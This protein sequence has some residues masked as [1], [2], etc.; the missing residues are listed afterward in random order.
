M[1]NKHGMGQLGKTNGN[2]MRKLIV[3]ITLIVLSINANALNVGDT[4][5]ASNWDAGGAVLSIRGKISGAY[6]ISNA[7][8]DANLFIQIFDTTITLGAN[9]RC[10]KFSAMWYG[11]NPS[12]DDNSVCLQK[13]INACQDRQ[14][15]LFIPGGNY[16]TTQPLMVIKGEY[17]NYEQTSIKITGTASFWDNGGGSQIT[18][19]GD[20]CAI[21]LQL[22]KGTEISHLIISGVWVSP[23]GT[24][25]AYF[26]T[27]YDNYENQAEHGNGQGIWVDPIGNWSQRSGSTGCYFHDLKIEKFKTLIQIS[28]SISQNGEIMIFENIQFGNAK[29]GVVTSQAQEKGNVFRGIYSWGN[30]HTLFYFSNSAGNY[31]LDGANIAG[32]CIRLFRV[33]SQSWFPTHIT[34]YYAENIGTVGSI[35]SNMPMNVSHSVFDFIVPEK[36]GNAT[37]LATNNAAIKFDNCQFRY[38]GAND[39]LKFSGNATFENCL[40]SGTVT[41][42]T[43]IFINY[44]DGTMNIT[45]T[46]VVTVTTDTLTTN[47]VKITLRKSH[48]SE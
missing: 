5:L 13:S 20:S 40:F 15:V 46:K 38:Y 37:L 30:I 48:L 28:N 47:S 36:V 42:S 10:E 27:S 41:G 29:T 18:Y 7:I 17:G 32:R 26:N 23:N 21:G 8:I 11:A 2:T 33:Y 31:Y 45:G 22:N 16:K 34:N 6:E 9:I 12:N 35:S 24:D 4:T 43:G 14:Y 3:F 39:N 19:S 1:L 44:S 25:S